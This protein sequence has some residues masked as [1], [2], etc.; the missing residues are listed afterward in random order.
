MGAF[1][2]FNSKFL[3]SRYLSFDYNDLIALFTRIISDVVISLIIA[4]VSSSPIVH[5][6]DAII[7]RH[8]IYYWLNYSVYIY[9]LCFYII[10]PL[11]CSLRIP[12]INGSSG[13][14]IA[15]TQLGIIMV[16]VS[17]VNTFNASIRESSGL[18]R[19]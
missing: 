4:I 5:I 9:T 8:Y 18:N 17:S 14:K 2:Y 10:I 13:S 3:S 1:S 7:Y 15:N 16:P 6:I 11:S 19:T 12:S